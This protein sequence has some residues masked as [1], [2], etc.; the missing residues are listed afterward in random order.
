MDFPFQR[1]PKC[2]KISGWDC[3]KS[4]VSRR[5][6]NS[7]SSQSSG[8]FILSVGVWMSFG[9]QHRDNG[10]RIKSIFQASLAE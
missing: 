8:S 7:C 1:N 5:G 3:I 10:Q 4:N 2:D 9:F 6:K